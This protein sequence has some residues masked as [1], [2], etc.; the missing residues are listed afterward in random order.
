[1]IKITKL[2]IKTSVFTITIVV[3]ITV[4]Q[5]KGTTFLLSMNKS[6]NTQ[7][8]LSKF[9]TLI[10]NEYSEHLQWQCKSDICCLICLCLLAVTFAFYVYQSSNEIDDYQLV[11][12]V[13]ISL[14]R[15][16]KL[17]IRNCSLYCSSCMWKNSPV[18]IEY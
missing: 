14:L 2:Q 6:F 1:M 11:F 15:M 12:I 9:S 5:K 10:V 4:G 13:S 16:P 18:S 7:C 8:S 17:N 3:V